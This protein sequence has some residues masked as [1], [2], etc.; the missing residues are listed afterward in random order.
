[1][2]DADTAKIGTAQVPARHRDDAY[3]HRFASSSSCTTRTE[4]FR[5]MC[6]C[7]PAATLPGPT[8]LRQANVKGLEWQYVDLERKHAWIPGS[9]HKNGKPHSVPLNEMALSVLRKQLGKHPTRVFTFRGEPIGQVNTKAWTAA[10]ERAGIEDFRW[11]DLRHTFATW[12]R[13][14]GTPTHELQ[15]LGGWKTGAMVER[16]AHVAPEAL[17]GAAARLDAMA[18]YAVATPERPT[19]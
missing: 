13:Q 11:H 9:K 2:R 7:V 8:G 15:R 10:L 12:H 17:Q 1:M 19:A 6:S 14:A 5:S 18:G 3:A 16:Y 4:T